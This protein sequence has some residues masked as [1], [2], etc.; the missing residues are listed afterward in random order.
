MLHAK[1]TPTSMNWDVQMTNSRFFKSDQALVVCCQCYLL[2]TMV[3]QGLV[4]VADWRRAGY[5][6]EEI[7][8]SVHRAQLQHTHTHFDMFVPVVRSSCFYSTQ[9]QRLKL[10]NKNLNWPSESFC[11]TSL[12]DRHHHQL[13]RLNPK[14]LQPARRPIHQLLPVCGDRGASLHLCLDPAPVLLQTSVS[15]LHAASRRRHDS[16]RSPHFYR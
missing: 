8:H 15:V 3:T 11:W 13:L 4:F 6:R 5:E 14:H 2:V 1:P 12:Q 9:Q 16:L 10:P 7:H